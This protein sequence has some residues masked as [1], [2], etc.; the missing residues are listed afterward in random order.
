MPT[1]K[2]PSPRVLVGVRLPVP[3]VERMKQEADK[4]GMTLQGFVQQSLQFYMLQ[5]KLHRRTKGA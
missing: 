5:L 1:M 3:L 2:K 4:R